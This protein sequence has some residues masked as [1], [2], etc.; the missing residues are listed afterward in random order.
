MKKNRIVH[1]VMGHNCQTRNTYVSGA[2]S[3][4]KKAL[5]HKSCIEECVKKHDSVERTYWIMSEKV[6]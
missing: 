2:F 5:E 1:L 6:A 4:R 3:S